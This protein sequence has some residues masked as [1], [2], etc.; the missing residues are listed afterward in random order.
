MTVPAPLTARQIAWRLFVTCWIVYVLHFATDVVREHYPA[1]ALADHLSFRL[2][3]YGGLHPD[4][5]ETPG[6]G[7]HI[8]NNP[9]G[10]MVAAI[11]YAIFKPAVD[12]V[13]RKVLERR[14]A[15]GLTEPPAF[16][17]PW[18]NARR[19]YAEAWRRGLDIKLGLAAFIMQA[20]CMAPSSAAAAVLMFLVLRSLVR[21]DRAALW[22]SLLYAFGT[23]VFFRTGFL[24]HNLMMG[25]IAFAGMAVVWHPWGP[26]R[27]PART[28]AFLA[29]LAGGT[30]LLFDYSGAVLLAGLG[31][32][33][34][35]KRWSDGGRPA[36]LQ[37]AAWYTIGALGPILLLWFY[38][39]EAFGNPFLPGQSWMPPVEWIDLGYKGYQFPPVPELLRM[40]L[41]DHRFGLF[42]AGPVFLLAFAYPFTDRGPARVVPVLEAL[43]LLGLPVA[44]WLFFGGNNYTRL[45]F[46]T[47]IRYLTPIFPFLFVPAALVL[48]R[49]RP[50]AGYAWTL[51][52]LLVSWPLAMY[53]EVETPLGLLDPIVRTFTAGFALPALNTL[54]QT[55]GQ[56]GDFFAHGVS[57]LP[58]FVAAGAVIYGLWS[59]R[60][61][62]DD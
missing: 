41:V 12:L 34:A 6:R 51:A 56:Y 27:W 7:W 42:V 35:V 57:P 54:R 11:P 48:I 25:H 61:R 13:V 45:Q 21:S 60:F 18:P 44:M 55:S 33:V 17:T 62:R 47:G 19:F 20:F 15:S 8:G 50:L 26:S 1:I 37:G 10:S 53:R 2:D 3:E 14:A 58:L 23:P 52:A 43:V 38:Q 49:L 59:P 22:L 9:G 46:N 31:G 5:F 40:L 32:Y 28:T 30:A 24:N 36:A 16:N 39:Y 4:L 29:G